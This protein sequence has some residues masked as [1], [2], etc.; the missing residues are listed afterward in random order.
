MQE[1]KLIHEFRKNQAEK[2]IIEL[3][4]YLGKDVI[5][6]WVYYNSGEIEDDWRP[7]RKGICMCVDLIPE[8]KVGIDKAYEQWQKEEESKG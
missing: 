5:S 3:K 8:L 6:I 1:C 2:I 7:S 4:N